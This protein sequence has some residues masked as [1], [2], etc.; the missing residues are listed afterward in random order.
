MRVVTIYVV[1]SVTWIAFSDQ[2]AR[3][4]VPDQGSLTFIQTAKGWGFV[5]LTAIL[6]HTLIS[7]A[8]K[9]AAD[10]SKGEAE[11][12]L[13]LGQI[14]ANIWTTDRD[15]RITSLRGRGVRGPLRGTAAHPLRPEDVVGTTV[16]ERF[17]TEDP[18]APPIRAHL[19]ALEGHET[20][21]TL[22]WEG[23]TLGSV[24][25]PLKGAD[26]EPVGCLGFS[27]DITDSVELERQRLQSLKRLEQANDRAGRLLQHLVRAE[28]EERKRVAAGIHDDS[29]QAMTSAGM[30]LDLLV[31]RMPASSDAEIARRAR[32]LV[33]TSMK[34]LRSLVFELRPLE[35]DRSGLG[36]AI[37]L[38]LEKTEADAKVRFEFSDDTSGVLD[39]DLAFLVYR[40]VQ[41]ALANVRK[42][43]RAANVTVALSE[44][45]GG[46]LAVVGDDGI[47]FDAS[48]AAPPDH[49]GLRDMA[50][51]AEIAGGWCR[52][53]SAPATGTVVEAWVPRRVPATREVKHA[54]ATP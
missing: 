33:R 40:I 28:A 20:E 35:L 47:G 30:A 23:R 37:Q 52:V 41:E 6:L 21:Y 5:V 17:G 27:R 34:R 14:P 12:S 10:V 24:V 49:F 53:E 19:R 39:P 48:N 13:V 44:S 22:D 51:R 29:I 36:P 9:T 11:I 45:D 4:L 43:A 42:H 26:G 18:T 54:N 25:T 38:L 16:Y 32:D 50:E 15:L 31:A 1:V 3:R 46:V 7:R 2:I 8:L